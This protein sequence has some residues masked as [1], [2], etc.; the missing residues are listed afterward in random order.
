MVTI[1]CQ[2]KTLLKEFNQLFKR[3]G[4][5]ARILIILSVKGQSKEMSKKGIKFIAEIGMNHNG[6]FGLFFELIKQASLSGADFA[7]FQLGWRAKPGEINQLEKQDVA[8][9]IKCCEHHNI[10]PL[11][12]V[13]NRDSFDLA[14]TFDL[15]AY[16][17]ASR[18]VNEETE[19]VR[20]I[21]ATGKQVFISLGMTQESKPFGIA[22]SIIYLWCQSQYPVHPWELKDFPDSFELN[23]TL[24]FS[25]HSVGIELALIAIMRGAEVIEKHFTLDKSD[26]TIRDHALSLTPDEFRQMVI[27]GREIKKYYELGI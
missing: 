24:G 13:F 15:Q 2:N 19:L 11:F 8:K 27:L 12:S 21:I 16:K 20:D 14:Q 6:N 5:S 26:V 10:Q 9:I 4:F 7:K 1:K 25:D 3:A 18:T 22:D 23:Q 17:I